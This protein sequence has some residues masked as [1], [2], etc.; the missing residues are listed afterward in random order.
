MRRISRW[1]TAAAVCLPL[2]S[3]GV[4]AT[5]GGKFGDGDRLVESDTKLIWGYMDSRRYGTS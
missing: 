2:T 5:E 3:A 1:A 4:A